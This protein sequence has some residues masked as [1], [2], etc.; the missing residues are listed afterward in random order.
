MSKEELKE[1]CWPGEVISDGALTRVLKVV[2]VTV[3]DDGVQQHTIQTLIRH[4]Y[5]F[6]ASV[7]ADP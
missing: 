4:G 5:R 7:E 6:I 3:G 2:R 1:A